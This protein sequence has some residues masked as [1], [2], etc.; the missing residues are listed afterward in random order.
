[1]FSR[2]L[3]NSLNVMAMVATIV[4]AI[5]AVLTVSHDTKTGGSENNHNHALSD[6]PLTLAPPSDRKTGN[7]SNEPGPV[8]LA[9]NCNANISGSSVGRDVI[10]NCPSNSHNLGNPGPITSPAGPGGRMRNGELIPNCPPGMAYSRD[11]RQCMLLQYIGGVIPCGP[12]DPV[13]CR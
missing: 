12:D 6:T 9:Q 13:I 11:Q 7:S 10:V 3:F 4:A 2:K 8:A 5:C 1:M